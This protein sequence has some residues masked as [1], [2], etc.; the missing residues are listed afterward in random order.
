M[1]TAKEKR[2][3]RRADK[4]EGNADAKISLEEYIISQNPHLE[5]DHDTFMHFAVEDLLDHW[6]TDGDG[7]LSLEEFDTW[8][9]SE[10]NLMHTYEKTI[11]EETGM[12]TISVGSSQADMDKQQEQD[13]EDFDT[14][15]SNS[16]KKL[17]E[18]ELLKYMT[19][20]GGL[21]WVKDTNDLFMYADTNKDN[22][23]SKEEVDGAQYLSQVQD[24]ANIGMKAEL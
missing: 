10:R 18:A 11:N 6:D 13:D 1:Q 9:E 8:K 15:D 3:L 2:R 19:A 21:K 23:I 4:E 20:K 14:A 24:I 7:D 12:M 16:D 17:T 22:K 5:S